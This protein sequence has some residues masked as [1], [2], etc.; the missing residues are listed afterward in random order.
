MIREASEAAMKYFVLGALASGMLLY[1]MSMLYGV[2]GTL[3]LTELDGRRLADQ[4]AERQR[5]F[6]A[7]RQLQRRL[8]RLAGVDQHDVGAATGLTRL[9]HDLERNCGAGGYF[10]GERGG[11]HRAL[12]DGAKVHA[13]VED[14]AE[15]AR[16]QG[17]A[18]GLHFHVGLAVVVVAADVGLR[19]QPTA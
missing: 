17:H 13:V 19:D 15:V 4:L 6:A 7:E 14:A 5:A 9:K 1:G 12:G 16:V 18:L 2:S 10:R 3:D 11:Q 8:L